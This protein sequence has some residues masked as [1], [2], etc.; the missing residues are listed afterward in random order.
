[1]DMVAYL[2]ALDLFAMLSYTELHQVLE[3]GH[4]CRLERGEYLFRAGDAP[5]QVHVVMGG[6]IEVVRPTPD[7]PEPT[8]VAYLTP[9]DAIGDMALFTRKARR[10]SGRVPEF[11][12]IFTLTLPEFQELTRT[13]P[14]YGLEIAAA[15]ARRLDDFINDMRRQ[16]RRK[17]LS[18]K[19]KFFDLPTVVQTLVASNQTGLLTIVDRWGRPYAEVLLLEGSVDRARCQAAEGVEAFYQIFQTDGQ[20]EFFFRTVETPE[21]EKTSGVAIRMTAM[22]LLM[23]AMRLIDELPRVC[24]RLPDPEKRYRAC[25]DSLRWEDEET[26][27]IAH[28]VWTKMHKPRLV[29]DLI[30]EVACSTFTLYRIAAELFEGGQI[31]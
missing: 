20:G 10:S 18:G 13:V 12:D 7:S 16:K 8:P 11:A 31:S 25:T 9:G 6:S 4:L 30:D 23:E 1:M 26:T 3:T 5:D 14:N 17:E 22:N 27:A 28:E 29:A 24:G 15:F 2:G 21:P 19:L